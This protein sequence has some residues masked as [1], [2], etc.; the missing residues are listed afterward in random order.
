MILHA[1]FHA[2]AET[3][4]SA[5]MR[6]STWGFAVVEAVHLLGLAVF[7]GAV[8]VI[9]FAALGIGFRRLPPS[10]TA[11]SLGPVLWIA[12]AALVASGVLLVGSNPMKYYFNAAFRTKIALLAA[13][14]L[15]TAFVI[16]RTGS[17]EATP[18]DARLAAALT[19]VLW[20]G[21]GLAGRLIGLL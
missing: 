19:L 7:G 12:L 13:A 21:V 15:G 6:G 5:A 8:L 9:D 2:F 17:A 16:R 3:P 20:L 1:L 18:L 10:I 4:L 11:R 14:A